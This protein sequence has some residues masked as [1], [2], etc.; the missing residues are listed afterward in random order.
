MDE[1]FYGSNRL[2]NVA[3]N[4]LLAQAGIVL[5]LCR[6][7]LLTGRAKE[8]T[9]GIMGTVSTASA[10][11][12]LGDD[13]RFFNECVMLA[14]GFFERIL[15]ICYL[16]ICHNVDFENYRKHTIQKAHR[17]LEQEF[18][19][20]DIKIGLKYSSKNH[21]PQSDILKDALKSFSSKTGG[22]RKRWPSHTIPERINI[23]RENS[24]ANIGLFLHYQLAFYTD[25]SEALHGTFYG[26]TFHTGAYSP[27]LDTSDIEEVKRS[28]QKNMT[29][30]FCTTGSLLHE[31][32]VVLKK[33]NSIDDYFQHSSVNSDAFFK[34]FKASMKKQDVT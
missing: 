6:T 8:I 30:L 3:R 10:I 21:A 25:A 28:L 17:K 31:L 26:I 15:N 23:L 29:L 16:L 27:S 32:L 4:Y 7:D 18:V 22:E 33:N 12:K 13:E 1:L 2:A 34:I 11:A 20:G 9:S 14:R 24:K 19:A 5:E